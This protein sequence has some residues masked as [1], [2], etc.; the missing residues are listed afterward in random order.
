MNRNKKALRGNEG[1]FVIYAKY[2]YLQQQ[3]SKSPV[4]QQQHADQQQ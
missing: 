3:H 1:L 2:D 4:V